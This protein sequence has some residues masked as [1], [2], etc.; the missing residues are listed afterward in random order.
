MWLLFT[1]FPVNTNDSI[2]LLITPKAVNVCDS[3]QRTQSIS[4]R[5]FEKWASSSTA[6][7]TR[8]LCP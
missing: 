5:G 4:A 2:S 1:A 3:W 7:R 8:L 6:T